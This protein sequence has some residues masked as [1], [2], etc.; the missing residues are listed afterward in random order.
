[1]VQCLKSMTRLQT[2]DLKIKLC[3]VSAALLVEVL[4][5]LGEIQTLSFNCC[6][7]KEPAILA[8]IFQHTNLL[9]HLDV[10]SIH[11]NRGEIRALR[12]ILR[13]DQ[14]DADPRC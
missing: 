1:M 9:T 11:I 4:P 8:I 7:V 6:V 3:V 13:F 10:W 2:L 12:L 5:V 14:D